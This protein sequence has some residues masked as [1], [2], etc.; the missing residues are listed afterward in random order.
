MAYHSAAQVSRNTGFSVETLRY[1]ERIG[2]LD[3]V[4][5]APSGRRRFS[6]EQV[7]WISHL[8]CLRETGMPIRL[9]SRYAH[10]AR[11]GEASAVE[12]RLLLEEHDRAIDERIAALRSQ[13]QRIRA[14][15]QWYRDHT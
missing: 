14:K 5:R 7:E 13:Q 4:E 1:Y 8:R 11:Q 15:I 10:L 2:L 6:D 12:R 3:G 9:M